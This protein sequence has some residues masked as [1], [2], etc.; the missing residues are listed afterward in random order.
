MFKREKPIVVWETKV[1]GTIW[2]RDFPTSLEAKAYAAELRRIPGVQW[3]SP[4]R[5]TAEIAAAKRIEKQLDAAR[6]LNR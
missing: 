4:V 3:A 1:D 5:S 6:P 2:T